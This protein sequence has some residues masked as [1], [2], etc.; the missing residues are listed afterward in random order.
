M[1]V[2]IQIISAYGKETTSPSIR[3]ITV[4]R[5]LSSRMRSKFILSEWKV[6][7]QEGLFYGPEPHLSTRSVIDFIK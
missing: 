4:L 7:V 2:P 5:N 3:I 6:Y 1:L